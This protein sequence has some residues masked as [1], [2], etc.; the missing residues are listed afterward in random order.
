ML[1]TAL[2]EKDLKS[3]HA[4]S[5]HLA[6]ASR[7]MGVDSVAG[8]CEQITGAVDSADDLQSLM[9]PGGNC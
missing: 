4:L 8:R 3:A 2:L 7:A 5:E 1:A 9:R 6:N